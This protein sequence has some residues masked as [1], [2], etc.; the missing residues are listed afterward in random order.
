M[1]FIQKRR[2]FTSLFLLAVFGSV[3]LINGINPQFAA[4][5]N[6]YEEQSLYDRAKAWQLSRAVAKCIGAGQGFEHDGVSESDL[7]KGKWMEGDEE[8]AGEWVADLAEGDSN[9]EKLEC[10]DAA[11]AAL[12]AMGWNAV[13]ALCKMN[14]IAG[15]TLWKREK[16]SSDCKTGSG[17]L[18]FQEGDGK[19]KDNRTETWN[20]FFE[21]EYLGGKSLS[22]SLT[23]GMRY[24]M[25]SESFYQECSRDHGKGWNVTE[26]KDSF[27]DSDDY[28]YK[29]KWNKEE[30]TPDKEWKVASDNNNKD[31]EVN[32]GG[33]SLLVDGDMVKC[34]TA[35]A[36]INTYAA[37]Y[38]SENGAIE[39]S[40]D[41]GGAGTGGSA[42]P[43]CES[44]G[45][46][47]AW[48]MCQALEVVDNFLAFID[49][50]VGNLLFID[51]EV[52][53]NANIAA[54]WEVMRNLALLILVPMMMF[55]VIGTALGFGP[56]DAYTVK[57][58]LPRMFVA[59]IFIAISL[60]LTQFGIALSNAAGQGLGNLIVTASPSSVNTLSDIFSST[61]GGTQA[62]LGLTTIVAGLGGFAI[63]GMGALLS[64]GFVA[65]IGLLIG[66]IILV[67]RQ[68]LLVSLI[69]I[70]PL[71][72]LVWIFPGNDKM[73]NIWKG[74]FV[75]MLLMYPI[76]TV[77]LAS[78]KL[79][80]GIM[81]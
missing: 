10:Q 50:Q 59:V 41:T 35:A 30:A 56:F 2:Q 52:Y 33:Y 76:I 12:S 79:V 11:K 28:T 58:A 1:K 3:V 55:M 9:D 71:A 4:A 32:V 60:P 66:F 5:A 8:N 26:W 63:A 13:D 54:A 68:V 74:T 78:G 44:E 23:D 42:E 70:A 6:T 15:E 21:Q 45:G 43:T 24:I 75:A 37:A 22:A 47:T 77:L 31:H 57:K 53:D 16:S 27:S 80:A 51:S 7:A 25:Y 20:E 73:W 64:F 18:D 40:I 72:I 19:R 46:P 34:S 81:N 38:V 36:K 62:E 61:G 14:E 69:I 65:I 17:K 67:M 48:F 39:D 29:L 49:R